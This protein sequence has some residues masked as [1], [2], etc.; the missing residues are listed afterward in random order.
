MRKRILAFVLAAAMVFGDAVPALAA[1]MPENS[2]QENIILDE[3]SE[4]GGGGFRLGG[5]S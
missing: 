2:G 1:E 3:N 4:V 5:S